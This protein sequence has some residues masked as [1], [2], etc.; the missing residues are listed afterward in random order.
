M[1]GTAPV[2][3]GDGFLVAYMRIPDFWTS[4]PTGVLILLAA[5]LD[6]D[7]IIIHTI[8]FIRSLRHM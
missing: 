6:S 4:Q 8:N 1:V 3:L 5:C 2:G 7:F